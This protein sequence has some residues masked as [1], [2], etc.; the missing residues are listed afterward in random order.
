MFKLSILLFIFMVMYGLVECG[1][2]WGLNLQVGSN[3]KYKRPN[4]RV[5]DDYVDYKQ[6]KHL[7]DEINMNHTSM[8]E[9]S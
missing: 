8:K 2:N 6:L 7:G 9:E 1:I 3:G 4:K 5:A